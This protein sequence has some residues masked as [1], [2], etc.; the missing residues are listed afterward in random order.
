M[1]RINRWFKMPIG[2]Q[3][4]NIGSE[5]GRAIRRKNENDEYSKI[6][7]AIKAIELIGLTKLDPKNIKRVKELNYCE[8]ELIDYIF[9]NNLYGNDDESI[10]KFYNQWL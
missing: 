1:D 4:S 5:V 7:Y 3:I 2:M 8:I 10:M 6:N 9:D